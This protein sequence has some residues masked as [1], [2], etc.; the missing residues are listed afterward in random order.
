M[1]HSEG[2][3]KIITLLIINVAPRTPA[4]SYSSYILQMAK[5]RNSSSDSPGLAA[6]GLIR[7]ALGS[8]L[9]QNP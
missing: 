4:S 7:Q 5:L 9:L 3:V 1:L 6:G 2:T 8:E